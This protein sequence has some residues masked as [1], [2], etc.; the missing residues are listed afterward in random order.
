MIKKVTKKQDKE[1]RKG[2]STILEEIGYEVIEG[3]YYMH[4]AIQ[5]KI[6]RM[7][8]TLHDFSKDDEL[9]SI[10]CRFDDTE[11]ARKLVGHWKYNLHLPAQMYDVKGVLEAFKIHLNKVL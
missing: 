2:I 4:Y 7:T 5:T 1:L 6:G 3:S 11:Q 9:F 8:V 10:Y